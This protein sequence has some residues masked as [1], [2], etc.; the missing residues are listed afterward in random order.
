MD[1]IGYLDVKFTESLY[2]SL[3][4][5][6]ENSMDAIEIQN[7]TKFYGSVRGV[8]NLSLN[9]KQ[10]EIVGFV[11]KNGAG[12]STTIRLLLNFIFPT[13]GQIK[14]F[15]MDSVKE[16]KK[17]KEITAY[18]P[19]EINYYSNMRVKELLDYAETFLPERDNDYKEKLL[20]YFELNPERKISELSLGNKK[21][22]GIIV[23]LL[24]KAKLIILDEPTSG[25]DPLMQKKFFHKLLKERDRGATI[26]LS[27]HNLSDVEQYCDRV[28]II[29][30]GAIVKSLSQSHIRQERKLRVT[31]KE[32]GR[33]QIS[34]IMNKDIN[35]LIK[36]LANKNLESL[37]LKYQSLEE[38]LEKYYKGD[39]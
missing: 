30:D 35:V 29:K 14:I 15:G 9:I 32:K 33:A 8:E 37:E 3:V 23:C 4:I 39:K 20:S 27:S 38:E 36:E 11:G 19:G 2:E 16:T 7:L 22:V 26:F 34:Y 13:D 5:S 6:K 21:K 10:G 24:K 28:E 25:L 17:I 1:S 18:L 12:K 31:Y